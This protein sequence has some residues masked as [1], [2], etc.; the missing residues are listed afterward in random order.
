MFDWY[1]KRKLKKQGVKTSDFTRV[2]GSGRNKQYY[3]AS[4]G[5]W[6]Y[7]YLLSSCLDSEPFTGKESDFSESKYSYNNSQPT[8]NNC[9]TYNNETS[10]S[11]GFD[12][13]Y[14]SSSSYS[15]DSSSSSSD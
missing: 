9:S 10:V 7:W 14:D 15:S 13:S 6:V 3:N 11:S 8:Y 4:T 2:R 1:R 12:S 5:E